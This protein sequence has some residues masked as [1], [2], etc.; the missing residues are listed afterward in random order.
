MKNAYTWV[1]NI[2]SYYSLKI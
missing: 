1:G 2:Q